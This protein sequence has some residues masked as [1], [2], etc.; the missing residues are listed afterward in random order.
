MITRYLRYNFNPIWVQH[1]SIHVKKYWY[2]V[3]KVP[4]C[5][6]SYRIYSEPRLEPEPKKYFRLRSTHKKIK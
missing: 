1:T 3:K 2:Q 6:G 5:Q 4:N